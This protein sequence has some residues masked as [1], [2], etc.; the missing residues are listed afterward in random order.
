MPSA[1]LER[2]TE[3]LPRI[4]RRAVHALADVR[5]FHLSEFAR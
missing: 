5:Q 2:E 4:K 3:H 1:E